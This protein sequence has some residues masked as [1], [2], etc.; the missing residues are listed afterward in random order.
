MAVNGTTASPSNF[1][2]KF[3][4]ICAVKLTKFILVMC[5]LMFFSCPK[6]DYDSCWRSLEFSQTPSWW[7]GLAAFF[8]D[9]NSALAPIL[10]ACYTN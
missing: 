1:S 6:C 7:E 4:Q 3:M 8:Q 2:C 10:I 9:A 5:I